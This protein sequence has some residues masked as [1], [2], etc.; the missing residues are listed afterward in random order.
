MD[1]TKLNQV[2]DTKGTK[3]GQDAAS[4]CAASV[5]M[6]NEKKEKK[7]TRYLRPSSEDKIDA[8]FRWEKQEREA[9]H[10]INLLA[11]AI[12]GKY[13]PEF[14]T[15]FAHD[16]FADCKEFTHNFTKDIVTKAEEDDETKEDISYQLNGNTI[17][18]FLVQVDEINVCSLFRHFVEYAKSTNR[19]S[20]SAIIEKENKERE[21]NR[22]Q[23][24]NERKEKREEEKTK[25]K[26][27]EM[28]ITKLMAL[29]TP[30]Q[31][32]AIAAAQSAK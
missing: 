20:V 7:E 3:R 26:L 2:P 17:T 19:P 32:A 12:C 24:V 1:T 10:N 14:G 5:V 18:R 4:Q 29:L 21:K 30:E 9:Q 8:F 11:I 23:K 15:N 6:E 28:D 25:G 13:A 22:L 31:L 16:L 27:Q